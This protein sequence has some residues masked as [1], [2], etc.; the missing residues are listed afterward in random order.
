MCFS[1]VIIIMNKNKITKILADDKIP[2]LKGVLDPFVEIVYLDPSNINKVTVYDKDALIIRTRTKCNSELLEGSKIRFIATATI[3]FDHIDTEYCK[4]KNI[5]WINAPGCNSSSVMQYMASALLKIAYKK[6]INLDEKT[7]G[8]IGVGNVG[9]K[10]A[11]L[12]KILGLNVLLND[13]PRMRVE[14]NAGFVNLDEL[15]NK[16]DII[17]FHV[18]LIRG[19]IDN[20]YHMADEIF[21]KRFHNKKLL[22]NTSRGEVIKTSDLKNAVKNK[23][24]DGCILDVWENEP[25]IDKELLNI[26]D[27]ATPHIAGYSADGKANGTSVCVNNINS[28]FKLG[29]KEDWYPH[30]IPLPQKPEHFNINCSDK[31]YQQ[32][33]YDIISYTYD[34]AED[35]KLLR[36]SPS[37]FE[38]QR[39]DYPVRREFAFY[40]INLENGDKK[41][42]NN[43]TKLG[44]KITN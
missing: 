10:V 11:R 25:I 30:E 22:I 16:S 12:A 28:F 8:I 26:I 32:I 13:P 41:I 27:I 31:L 21:F 4:S 39:S 7:I 5:K 42:K 40:K 33:I 1:G 36:K 14:G 2:F 3:G 34:I 29:L 37:T 20:T 38:K 23:T 15:I 18:P 43:L 17:T 19:G 6:N 35:D 9:R 24:I 44:F